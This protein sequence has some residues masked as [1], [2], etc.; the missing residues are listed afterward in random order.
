M[1]PTFDVSLA[2]GPAP[3]LV[4]SAVIGWVGWLSRI[5][6]TAMDGMTP[7]DVYLARSRVRD[8]EP[9]V[10]AAQLIQRERPRAGGGSE[11]LLAHGL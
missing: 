3:G 4:Q 2:L 9:Q 1:H 10:A 5:D 11:G 8:V 6:A 7:G